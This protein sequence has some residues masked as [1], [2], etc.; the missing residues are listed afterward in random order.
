MVAGEGQGCM[1]SPVRACSCW[2]QITAG[3]S[4]NVADAVHVLLEYA[5]LSSSH[6]WC[7]SSSSHCS[8]RLCHLEQPRPHW[9]RPVAA[10]CK[11]PRSLRGSYGTCH[12]QQRNRWMTK[13]PAM[14]AV[15]NIPWTSS[16]NHSLRPPRSHPRGFP[17]C[18]WQPD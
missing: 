6:R 9:H 11:Y 16:P 1:I 2:L 10:T 13:Y 8:L 5:V 7:I 17:R 3:F 4:A 18:G 15:L 14:I 12:R